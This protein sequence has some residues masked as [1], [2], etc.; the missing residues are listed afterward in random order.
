MK[1]IVKSAFNK[2]VDCIAWRVHEPLAKTERTISSEQSTQLV[3]KNQYKQLN[4]AD[5]SK[6]S[7]EDVGFRKYSQNSEDGILLFIF[8]ILGTSNKTVVEIC[9]S[10][11]ISCNASNLVIN[12]GWRALL[13]DGDANAVEK[14]KQF[15]KSHPDTFTLPS[16]FE[17]AWI[18]R[19]NI[20]H[21]ISNNNI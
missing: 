2:L 9:A 5:I 13:F 4:P 10:D 11:G 1:N 3:L 7:F 16:V 18:T 6:Y 19:D 12:H 17:H 21:L 14:G 15:Y 8:S 20:K